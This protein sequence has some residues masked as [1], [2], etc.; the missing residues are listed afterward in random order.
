VSDD[1]TVA[2]V[3]TMSSIT[4]TA[5]RRHVCARHGEHDA[6][7]YVRTY[8]PPRGDG[9][10]DVQIDRVYCMHCYIEALDKMGVREMDPV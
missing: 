7:M 8:G 5:P 6:M 9:R 1:V 3:D 4:I 10:R 2:K